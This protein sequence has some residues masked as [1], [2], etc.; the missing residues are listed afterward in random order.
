MQEVVKLRYNNVIKVIATQEALEVSSVRRRTLMEA[1]KYVR[2]V[3]L[4][5][6]LMTIFLTYVSVVIFPPNRGFGPPTITKAFQPVCSA[7]ASVA[8]SR[9]RGSLSIDLFAGESVSLRCSDIS[10]DYTYCWKLLFLSSSFGVFVLCFIVWRCFST[11][12]LTLAPSALY[13]S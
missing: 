13:I 7:M 6:C 9:V 4:V 11:S 3:T 5:S 10:K 1:E 12:S 8:A 2:L